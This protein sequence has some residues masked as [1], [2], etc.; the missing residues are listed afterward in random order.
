MHFTLW[1]KGKRC[2]VARKAE[3]TNPGVV[4]AILR[5]YI[6]LVLAANGCF[7]VGKVGGGFKVGII[8]ARAVA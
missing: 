6:R 3:L 2:A 4:G 5:F 8:L 1:H 7:K